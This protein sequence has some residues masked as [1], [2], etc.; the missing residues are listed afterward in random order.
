[1][2]SRIFEVGGFLVTSWG[3]FGHELGEFLMKYG[4]SRM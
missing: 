2:A 4:K 3:I 1:M